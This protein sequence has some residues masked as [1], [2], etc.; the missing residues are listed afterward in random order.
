[1]MNS[2]AAAD[3]GWLL[4]GRS[5]LASGG[6][7]GGTVIA[8]GRLMSWRVTSWAARVVWGT[9]I[10]A[11]KTVLSS[12]ASP[13]AGHGNR[14]ARYRTG[15]LRAQIDACAEAFAEFVDWS[16]VDVL[17]RPRCTDRSRDAA[18]CSSRDGVTGEL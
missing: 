8:A 17:R 14:T 12:R 11:G 13:M 2:D 16:L 4:A 7:A 9:A 3:V 10:A 6:G 18:A 15:I 5:V 1:M